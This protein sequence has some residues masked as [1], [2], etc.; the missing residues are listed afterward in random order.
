M[1]GN[2]DCSTRQDWCAE[3]NNEDNLPLNNRDRV[4]QKDEKSRGNGA[5]SGQA[6]EKLG[7]ELTRLVLIMLESQWLLREVLAC[8]QETDNALRPVLEI[9][10]TDLKKIAL[11]R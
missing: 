2:G 3:E 5:H 7:E 10:R 9:I 1:D 4:R 11:N 8:I 6:K